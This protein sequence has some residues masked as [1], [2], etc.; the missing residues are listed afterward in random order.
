MIEAGLIINS[1]FGVVSKVAEKEIYR[2]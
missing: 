2:E 1:T